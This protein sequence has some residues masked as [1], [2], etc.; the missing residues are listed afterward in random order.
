MNVSPI[1]AGIL[2]SLISCQ[3]NVVT[4]LKFICASGNGRVT[5][6]Q[7][8]P[9]GSPSPSTQLYAHVHIGSTNRLTESKTNKQN[10]NHEIG[11]EY[12]AQNR[13]RVGGERMGMWV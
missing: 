2:S 5:S 13:R 10:K 12:Q 8:T 6:I 3:F 7:E 9:R 4:T 11:R 1:H